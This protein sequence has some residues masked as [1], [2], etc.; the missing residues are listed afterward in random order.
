LLLNH[1]TPN[2]PSST[3]KSGIIRQHLR[4]KIPDYRDV[5]SAKYKTARPYGVTA[6]AAAI[7]LPPELPLNPSVSSKRLK[8]CIAVWYRDRGQVKRLE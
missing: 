6:R 3:G 8:N 5:Y 4:N 1:P 7:A 2:I